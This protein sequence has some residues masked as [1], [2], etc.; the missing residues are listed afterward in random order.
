[1]TEEEIKN[2]PTGGMGYFT[3]NFELNETMDEIT[4]GLV[5]LYQ[6]EQKIHPSVQYFY[7]EYAGIQ[8][9]GNQ[10]KHVFILYRA[11]G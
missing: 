10:Q 2:D 8:Q 4:Q 5:E 7:I 3:F 11:H 1:M 9:T 6:A